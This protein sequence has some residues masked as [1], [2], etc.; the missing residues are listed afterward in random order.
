MHLAILGRQP[1]LGL[2]ELESVYGADVLTPLLSVGA[3]LIDKDLLASDLEQLGG[4]TK[5]AKITSKVV[6]SDWRTIEKS[7]VTQVMDLATTMPEGKIVIGMSVFGLSVPPQTI[8]ATNIKLKRFIQKSGRSVR[9]VPNKTEQLNSAQVIH[10]HLLGQRGIEIVVLKYDRTTYIAHTI[11]EQ[12]INAYASRDQAR[13]FRD[14]FVGM[15]PP[16]LAQIMINLARPTKDA[17]ILDPFCGTGVILQEAALLGYSVYGTDLSEK[18][19]EYSKGNLTWLEEKL[20]YTITK[21]LEIADAMTA[22]W[23]G[24]INAVVSETYL[25][26]PFSAPP[27]DEKLMEVRR[28]CNHII[29]EF[30][31]N[32][33]KQIASGTPLCIAVPAWRNKSGELS[34]LPLIANVQSL[35]YTRIPLKHVS[36]KDLIY[37]RP[38]Q[39]VARQLLVLNKK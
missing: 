22:N 32:I 20:A 34:H 7:L 9:V 23:D 3:T 35:G 4:T 27:S 36:D 37:F 28:N 29:A 24:P 17:T 26:Q 18:M 15:L 38:N 2:A 6:T 13:P 14:A 19:I 33:G 11:A 31:A 1:N 5:L 12:D 25:G 39:V 16:K 21:N 8:N 10:N 30:L